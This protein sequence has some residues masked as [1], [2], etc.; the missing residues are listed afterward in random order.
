MDAPR[1]IATRTEAEGRFLRLDTIEFVD[2]Q[3]RIR[4]WEAAMRRH[5]QGAVLVIPLLRPSEQFVLIRQYRPP[6]DGYVLEFPAGLIDAG[7]S[8]EQTAIREVIEETGYHGAVRRITGPACSSPGMTGETVCIAFMEIDENRPEN[9]DPVPRPEPGE[10]ITA[11]R[12][13]RASLTT[14][15]CSRQDAGIHVDSRTIAYAMGLE[16]QL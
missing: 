10:D 11:I 2:R 6:M 4:S 16:L 3:G 12:V 8:P 5:N 15:L 13:P 14:F 7:E 1:R 9:R